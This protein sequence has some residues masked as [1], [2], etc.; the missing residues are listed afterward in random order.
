MV[1]FG[2]VAN[3]SPAHHLV[4]ICSRQDKADVEIPLTRAGRDNNYCGKIRLHLAMLFNV[5]RVC[6][7]V[8]ILYTLGHRFAQAW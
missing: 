1:E 5:H 4:K 7:I 6:L 2:S 8:Y 3:Q